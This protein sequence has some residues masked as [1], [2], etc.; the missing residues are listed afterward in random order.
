MFLT[1]KIEELIEQIDALD[2]F[3]KEFTGLL[4]RRWA[5]KDTPFRFEMYNYSSSDPK[6]SWWRV[7]SRFNLGDTVKF[8][9]VLLEVPPDIQTKLLFNLDL[10]R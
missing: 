10:F 2:I 7:S 8:E 9:T 3:E 1:V 4:D 5:L 6:I